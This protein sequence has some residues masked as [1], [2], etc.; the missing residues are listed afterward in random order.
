MFLLDAALWRDI[1]KDPDDRRWRAVGWLAGSPILRTS[2]RRRWSATQAVLLRMV[3]PHAFPRLM[4]DRGANSNSCR[5]GQVACTRNGHPG[6]RKTA[7]W[8]DFWP[9]SGT[10][11]LVFGPTA[12]TLGNERAEKRFRRSW[13][14][15]S[16]SDT[17]SVFHLWPLSRIQALKRN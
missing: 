7:V 10:D 3:V 17:E 6:T 12:Q 1:S 4:V 2:L 9:Q 11:Y 14:C 16:E 5:N 15:V 8:D 13:V